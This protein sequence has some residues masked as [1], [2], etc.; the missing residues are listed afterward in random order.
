M[1][2]ASTAP[3]TFT[4]RLAALQR[5]YPLTFQLLALYVF[6]LPLLSVQIPSFVAGF[7]INP[8][9]LFI[10]GAIATALATI[11][12]SGGG[13]SE[14]GRERLTNSVLRVWVTYL[15]LSVAYYYI[16]LAF[17]SGLRF[18]ALESFFR[19][20]RGKPV[21]QL[22]AFL[23]YGIVPY[24]LVR[25]Y[26]TSANHRKIIVSALGAAI[27]L[28]LWY[29]YMQQIAF[30]FGL[31]VTGRL[32]YEGAE[33]TRIAGYSVAGIH[34]LRFYSIGGEPRD[35][36]AFAVG[37]LLFYLAWRRTQHARPGRLVTLAL[38]GSILLA[39]S[40]SALLVLA[41]FIVLA[42][43]DAV[44]QRFVSIAAVA[45]ITGIVLL[46]SGVLIA[47]NAERLFGERTRQYVTAAA[48]LGTDNR[49]YVR[50]LQT[51]APDLGGIFYVLELPE[52]PIHRSL[53]GFG[54]GNYGSGMGDILLRYFDYD[55]LR[56][57]SL[58]DSRSFLLKT[59][60]ET[61]IVGVILLGMVFARTL[62][63]SA[64]LIASSSD[65]NDHIRHVAMRYAY[66]AFFV[67]AMIQISFYHFIVM[68]LIDGE[69]GALRRRAS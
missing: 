1:P 64:R 43:I 44:R 38:G 9:R 31:P 39:M 36:G 11:C 7:S 27:L 25:R 5:E 29:G 42:V 17:G 54:F 62:R 14:F 46:V 58:E 45:R 28:L 12:V 21:G 26:A 61:G 50:L 68:G 57:G 13:T 60:V 16:L 19:S 48:T 22:I 37:A 67:A 41:V 59:L 51:Q 63:N 23:T 47:T 56:E 66:V 6:F 3:S 69:F 32:L 35:Y 2:S 8:A 15:L 49:D 30:R 20:W 24:L 65:R 53:L 55:I 18:G 34:M 10:T 4:L 40:T 33:G 52:R